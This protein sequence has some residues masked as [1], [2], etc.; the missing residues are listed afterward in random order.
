MLQAIAGLL[1][2][3][4]ALELVRALALLPVLG[5]L[6]AGGVAWHADRGR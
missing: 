4:T 1:H 5:G 6:L 2:E 3:G